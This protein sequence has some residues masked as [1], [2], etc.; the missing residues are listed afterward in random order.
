MRKAWVLGVAVGLLALIGYLLEPFNAASIEVTPT[1]LLLGALVWLVCSERSRRLELLPYV[2]LGSCFQGWLAFS[3]LTV[4]FFVLTWADFKEERRGVAFGLTLVGLSVLSVFLSV[5]EFA[6]LAPLAVAPVMVGMSL[7]G[8]GPLLLGLLMLLLPMEFAGLGQE[9]FLLF[10]GFVALVIV[11]GV[12]SRM[13]IR[14]LA[15]VLALGILAAGKLWLGWHYVNASLFA[16][17]VCRAA[18]PRVQWQRVLAL[19]FASGALPSSMLLISLQII[20]GDQTLSVVV[21]GLFAL[22]ASVALQAERSTERVES[23]RG[24]LLAVGLL[25]LLPLLRPIGMTPAISLLSLDALWSESAGWVL[26]VFGAAITMTA[27]GFA[28][29]NRENTIEISGRWIT[30]LFERLRASVRA[31]EIR[32]V[33]LVESRLRANEGAPQSPR[34]VNSNAEVW[35]WVGA[36]VLAAGLSFWRAA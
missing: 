2:V 10:S 31:R 24:I 9:R 8:R 27:V 34:V 19:L 36:A 25:P 33:L 18:L 35:F 22:C 17:L 14:D 3:A 30:T 12:V 28:I 5:S 15:W 16:L 7:S 11:S 13:S 29:G 32:T 26:G 21:A 1:R 4:S 6:L 20:P 23:G